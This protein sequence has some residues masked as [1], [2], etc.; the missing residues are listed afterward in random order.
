MEMNTA[1]RISEAKIFLRE[2]PEEAV[3]TVSRI[4]KLPSSTLQRSIARENEG[5]SE[6]KPRGGHNKILKDHQTVA[7]HGFIRR[8][9]TY[10]MPPTKPLILN[11]I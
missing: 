4:F 11:A 10:S 8:L 3:A 9:L 6:S 2:N 7:V 5:G 1:T